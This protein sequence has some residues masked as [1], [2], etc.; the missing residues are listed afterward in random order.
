[1]R[2]LLLCS[3]CLTGCL[4]AHMKPARFVDGSELTSK[5]WLCVPD[6]NTKNLDG[7]ACGDL[8]SVLLLQHPPAPPDAGTSAM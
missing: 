7:V 5:A 8:G 4:G 6:D 2:T 1:M 3:L